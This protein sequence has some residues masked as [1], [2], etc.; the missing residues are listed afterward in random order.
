MAESEEQGRIR[1]FI[2]YVRLSSPAD[3]NGGDPHVLR[4]A[5]EFRFDGID[6]NSFRRISGLT[7]LASTVLA[8]PHPAV[9]QKL[10]DA[11]A[12]IDAVSGNK[13]ALMYAVSLHHDEYTKHV[14]G[15]GAHHTLNKME[16]QEQVVRKLI[17]LGADVT[18]RDENGRTA[19]DIAL[20]RSERSFIDPYLLEMLVA[21]NPAAGIETIQTY[22]E[23]AEMLFDEDRKRLEHIVKTYQDNVIIEEKID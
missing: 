12:D 18:I 9:I 16:A 4:M 11:G 17:A 22:L 1:D 15:T 20:D 14:N 13:T 2:N 3:I 8:A 7:V 10:I 5:L 19:L 23:H 6:L 21:A